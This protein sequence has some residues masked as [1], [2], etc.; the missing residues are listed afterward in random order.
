MAFKEYI[1]SWR[2]DKQSI[3]ILHG[4]R[5]DGFIHKGFESAKTNTS[6]WDGY[7]NKQAHGALGNRESHVRHLCETAEVGDAYSEW[8]LVNW[9]RQGEGKVSR[10]RSWKGRHGR[11]HVD[12]CTCVRAGV[13]EGE[14][15]VSV[16]A[17]G[18]WRGQQVRLRPLKALS[19]KLRN[20]M[21]GRH[22][23]TSFLVQTRNQTQRSNL[24]NAIQSVL[25]KLGFK[26]RFI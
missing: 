1:A 7:N 19:A 13:R 18:R 4:E 17:G 9:K 2:W 15:Q 25:G 14:F 6:L 23:I 5:S 21:W 22:F 3:T 16:A 12:V 24:C 10:I 26:P 11:H 20:V 8:E